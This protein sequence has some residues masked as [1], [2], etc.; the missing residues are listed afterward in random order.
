MP[1]QVQRS[2]F[3]LPI[4]G[5]DLVNRGDRKLVLA[6]CGFV[7]DGRVPC[8]GDAFLSPCFSSV[9]FIQRDQV[10]A[11]VAGVDYQKVV[12]QNG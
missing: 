12:I 3:R 9:G 10:A 8:L 7:N 5:A 6:V 11:L 2:F 1:V 4:H